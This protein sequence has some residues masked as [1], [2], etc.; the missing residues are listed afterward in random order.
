[1]TNAPAC[2]GIIMDG[3]RRYAKERGLPT[4]EGHRAGFEKFKEAIDW[5]HEAGV[6]TSIFY[7]FSTENWKRSTEEVGYLMDLFAKALERELEP[8]K[9]RGIRIRFI[10]DLSRLPAGVR[11]RAENLA[12]ETK[13]A[14]NGTVVIALSYGARA[15]IVAA[16]NALSAQG[17]KDID[18]ETFRKALWSAD[19]PDPDLIIRTGGERR[20]SNF[21]LYQAAYSELA[22]TDTKWPDFS[23]TELDAIFADYAARERRHGA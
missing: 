14:K 23:R 8:I 18:E 6:T 2:V 19:I 22:F 5:L 4:F 11:E 21:L 7:A 9:E 10:G 3:N 13:E 1:M 15:E 12:E 20:L 16:A 17:N